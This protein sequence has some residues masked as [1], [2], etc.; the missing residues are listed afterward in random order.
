MMSHGIELL[1]I[2]PD[3]GQTH[4][5]SSDAEYLLRLTALL[6]MLMNCNKMIKI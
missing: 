1:I 3:T 6:L 4:L 2:I 5:S